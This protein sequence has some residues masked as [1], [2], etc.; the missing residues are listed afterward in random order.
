MEGE[1]AIPLLRVVALSP[2]NSSFASRVD[3]AVDFGYS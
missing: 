2:I 1:A 3:G